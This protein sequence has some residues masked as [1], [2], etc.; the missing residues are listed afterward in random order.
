MATNGEISERSHIRLPLPIFMTLIG[1]IVALVVATF[2]F[3][4][5]AVQQARTERQ[6]TLQHYVTVKEFTEWR[7]KQTMEERDRYE[8]LLNSLR[9]LRSSLEQ[10]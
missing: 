5:D 2:K 4:D 10:R 1:F 3:R 6:E 7:L 8:R 9:S